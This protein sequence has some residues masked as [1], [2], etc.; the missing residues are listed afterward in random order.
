[1]AGLILLFL[2]L[3][4]LFIAFLQR[5]EQINLTKTQLF[6]QLYERLKKD[7]GF[8]RVEQIL[9]DSQ[10]FDFMMLSGDGKESFDEYLRFLD[11]LI[12]MEIPNRFAKREA[13][14]LF[15]R[16]AELLNRQYLVKNYI[17][18]NYKNLDQVLSLSSKE[19][20]KSLSRK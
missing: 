3:L 9:D 20:K 4:F 19:E 2:I 7:E 11:S 16:P 17:A 6:L 14:L 10:S 5:Q 15:A 1:M 18:Q 8:K 13:E 12:Q